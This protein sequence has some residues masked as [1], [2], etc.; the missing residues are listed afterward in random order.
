M[1]LSSDAKDKLCGVLLL[2]G[3]AVLAG[4]SLIYAFCLYQL[5]KQESIYRLVAYSIMSFWTLVPPLWFWCNWRF[6]FKYKANGE[7]N[8]QY[9]THLHDLGR[10]VWLA[11]VGLLAIAF[12][13]KLP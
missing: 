12:G 5:H 8:P 3:N 1:S 2:L 9:V 11:V 6:C 10:N 4:A 13:F 7:Y